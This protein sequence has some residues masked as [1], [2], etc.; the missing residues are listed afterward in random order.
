MADPGSTTIVKIGASGETT[1]VGNFSLRSGSKFDPQAVAIATPY[2]LWVADKGTGEIAYVKPDNSVGSVFGPV[3]FPHF[4]RAIANAQTS[5]AL[6]AAVATRFPL[7][8]KG[9]VRCLR[10]D[11]NLFIE[12]A[13]ANPYGVAVDNRGDVYVAD[14]GTKKVFESSPDGSSWT[15]IGTFA[16]RYGVAAAANG[17]VYVADPGSKHVWKLAP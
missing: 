8:S 15:E 10:V 1:T 4:P 11:C 3:P 17:D 12:H 14:A 2:L 13:F 7:S 16:D 5:P 9:H 6:Y